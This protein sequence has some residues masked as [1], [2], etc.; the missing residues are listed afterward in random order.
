M[1]RTDRDR[2]TVKEV[3]SGVKKVV[4]DTDTWSR[5]Y[6]LVE[7][8]NRASDFIK[9]AADA[10]VAAKAERGNLHEGVRGFVEDAR[11]EAEHAGLFFYEVRCLMDGSYRFRIK[12]EFK[13]LVTNKNLYRYDERSEPQLIGKSFK[14]FRKQTVPPRR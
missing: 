4:I 6:G 10:E 11:K 5:I 7:E 3:F 14:V 1:E 9:N 13:G 8:A 12:P 2:R